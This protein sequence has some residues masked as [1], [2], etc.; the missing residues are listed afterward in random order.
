MRLANSAR[1][2][3][4]QERIV[5][6]EQYILPSLEACMKLE[7]Q[8]KIVAGGPL[9]GMIALALIVEADSV[10]ELDEIVESLPI[11]HLMETTVTPLTTF[12]RRLALI[13]TKLENLRAGQRGEQARTG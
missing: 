9:G 2:T 6:M 10:Q 11:W 5:F 12:G 3:G 7:E 1:P 8:K 13:R 4:L